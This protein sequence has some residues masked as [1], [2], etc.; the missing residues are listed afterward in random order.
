MHVRHE[1]EGNPYGIINLTPAKL[2]IALRDERPSSAKSQAVQSWTTPALAQPIEDGV[3]EIA[4]IGSRVFARRPSSPLLQAELPDLPLRGGA[5]LNFTGGLLGKVERAN[6]DDI[7]DPLKA[8]GWEVPETEA[9]AGEP[10]R[11]FLAELADGPQK[12]G[13][14]GRVW[15]PE[16]GNWRAERYHIFTIPDEAGRDLAVR[17]SGVVAPGKGPAGTPGN[18]TVHCRK[19]GDGDGY[20]GILFN[21]GN[22]YI[23]RGAE[24]LKRFDLGPDFDPTASHTLELRA[25]GNRLTLLVDGIEQGSVIDA[26]LS[27]GGSFGVGAS[28]GGLIEK[29]EYQWLSEP[30]AAADPV[31]WQNFLAELE[32][33]PHRNQQLGRFWKKADGGWRVEDYFTFMIPEEEGRDLAIRATGTGSRLS[34]FAREGYSGTLFDNGLAKIQRSEEVLQQF[35]LG[36]DFDASK[37][38]SVELRAVGNTLTLLVDDVELGSVQDDTHPAGG[39]FGVTAGDGSLVEKVE[40]RFLESPANGGAMAPSPESIVA[41]KKLLVEARAHLGGGDAEVACKLTEQALST[42]PDDL[43]TMAGAVSIFFDAKAP[44]RASGLA[45]RFAKQA[46]VE[47]PQFAAITELRVKLAPIFREYE[48]HLSNAAKMPPHAIQEELSEINAALALVPD[49]GKAL[50]AREKNPVYRMNPLPGRHWNCVSLGKP[51]PRFVPVDGLPNVLF[52]TCETRV[53]DFAAFIAETGHDM[54][55]LKPYG[56]DQ[57][58]NWQNP[59]FEQTDDHPV[60]FVSR[61]DAE[62]F[63]RW[64]TEKERAAGRLLPGQVYRLP[65][66]REWSAAMGVLDE[67]GDFP[68][69][70]VFP[71]DVFTWPQ[72]TEPP[73]NAENLNWDND[74]F[75]HTAPVGSGI[76]NRF[77]ICDLVGNVGEMCADPFDFDQANTTRRGS[78]FQSEAK[79]WRSRINDLDGKPVGIPNVGFRCVLD[80]K[81][82]EQRKVQTAFEEAWQAYCSAGR[83]D[84]HSI[85]RRVRAI[86]NDEMVLLDFTRANNCSESTLNFFADLP[87]THLYAVGMGGG[88]M[89]VTK[90]LPLRVLCLKSLLYVKA[91]FLESFRGLP[92]EWVHLDLNITTSS[93]RNQKSVEA[94]QGMKLKG[95]W[96]DAF[97]Y[98]ESIEP[99]RGM[100]LEELHLA[101]APRL[102]LSP[103]K[104]APLRSVSVPAKTDMKSLLQACDW[105]AAKAENF[106]SYR[107]GLFESL[108]WDAAQSG[109]PAGVTAVHHSLSEKFGAYPSCKALLDDLGSAE[110]ARTAEFGVKTAKFI[111]GDASA[112]GEFV[113][114]FNGHSY[115]HCDHWLKLDDAKARAAKLG[116]HLVAITSKEEN[117]F[118]IQRMEAGVF[119]KNFTLGLERTGVGRSLLDWKWVTGEPLAYHNWGPESGMSGDAAYFVQDKSQWVWF[120]GSKEGVGPYIIEWDTPTPHPPTRKSAAGSP[121]PTQRELAERLLGLKAELRIRQAGKQMNVRFG[122]KLPEG[123]FDLTEIVF[124]MAAKATA[125]TYALVAGAPN[126]EKLIVN[127]SVT[128]L[129]PVAGLTK[130]KS[131]AIFTG[132]SERDE[133]SPINEEEMR[134]LANLAEL[135]TLAL[136]NMAFTGQ[137]CRHLAGATKLESL[138]L[139]QKGTHIRPIDEAGATVIARLSSLKKLSLNGQ[140]FDPA[141]PAAFRIIAAMPDLTSFDLG[142]TTITRDMLAEIAKM[143]KLQ[144]L[145]LGTCELESQEFSLLAPLAD[146]LTELSFSYDSNLSDAG[147]KEIAD[148]LVNLK[149]LNFGWKNDCTGAALRELARLPKLHDFRYQKRDGL[150][151][152]EDFEALMQFPVLNQLSMVSCGLTDDYVKPL[153][154]C[155]DLA[156]VILSDNDQITDAALVHLHTSKTI[157]YVEVTGTQVTDAGIAALKAALPGCNV[158]R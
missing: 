78:A 144:S 86:I 113:Q 36:P 138:S 19:K 10:W 82:E 137:G 44:E 77:G 16:N 64:L 149:Q 26:T 47:H 54:S 129:A 134:H 156:A 123:D 11:D 46:P 94:F 23:R 28:E 60:V 109:D 67:P 33:G 115:L 155:P 3:L 108:I 120:H 146:R 150:I 154:R 110:F 111:G 70:R 13:Q 65:T 126:L 117:D 114:T 68:A 50:A 95:L 14:L 17:I 53:K 157:R 130:L 125:E 128:T 88:A 5:I 96:L 97:S 4:V 76:A 91:D 7:A 147:V 100:P 9:A 80:L 61:G 127:G 158:K 34:V 98:L 153:G 131:L 42:A 39:Q 148:T 69:D 72:G 73:H 57:T 40:Y 63:C 81:S 122:D 151:R 18:F 75:K 29:A 101:S 8:L 41:A 12:N 1:R 145:Q 133:G 139:G 90:K 51:A 52:S 121:V 135:E 99:L 84:E 89:R 25:V 132:G 102:D 38:H 103:V 2:E 32:N 119:Q 48:T 93:P 116:G 124:P 15:I 79:V 71:E 105:W 152:A 31:V 59:G 112:F 22:A 92:L 62:A 55:G 20:T 74:D 66:D 21:T 43:D 35:R 143:P 85:R 104:E 37:S 83:P 24:D 45:D 141:D 6:L 106:N 136:S 87:V 56:D 140:V 118:I 49:G 142:S 58:L 27:A 30:P 107:K